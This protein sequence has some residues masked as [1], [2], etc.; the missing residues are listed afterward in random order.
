MTT[1]VDQVDQD[2][3]EALIDYATDNAAMSEGR[4][5]EGVGAETTNGVLTTSNKVARS[6]KKPRKYLAD[7]LY[8]GKIAKAKYEFVRVDEVERAVKEALEKG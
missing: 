3:T 8:T 5:A 7:R 1:E 4:A 2:P 6:P